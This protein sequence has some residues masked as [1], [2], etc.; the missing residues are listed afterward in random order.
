MDFDTLTIAAPAGFGLFCLFLV[1]KPNTVAD[2][3]RVPARF[4]SPKVLLALRGLVLLFAV[5]GITYSIPRW[6]EHGNILKTLVYVLGVAAL[7]SVMLG[8]AMS[9]AKLRRR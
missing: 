4:R 3:Y 2:M 8:I 7:Y 9:V 5:S 1:F 6:Q